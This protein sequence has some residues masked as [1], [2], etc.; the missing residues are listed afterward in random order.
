MKI[1]LIT[2]GFDPI[3]S[4]HISYI[5]RAKLLASQTDNSGHLI[6]GIN[7]DHWLCNKKGAAFMPWTERQTI[8]SALRDVDEVISFNDEDG[9]AK[10]AIIQV[11]NKYPTHNIVFANGGD[12]T[13]ENIPEMDLAP[14]Y[15]NRVEFIFEVGGRDKQN[16]SSRILGNW[17]KYIMND[18]N[19]NI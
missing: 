15:L 12:R 1:V 10:D 8:I 11:L 4:G 18:K 3:H 13:K 17:N 7:S 6:V 19:H 16:S 2:G 5:K 14:E 9:S